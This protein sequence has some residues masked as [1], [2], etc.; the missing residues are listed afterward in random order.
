MKKN[1][2]YNTEAAIA[3]LIEKYDNLESNSYDGVHLDSITLSK[4]QKG[5]FDSISDYEEAEEQ[6]WKDLEEIE[7]FNEM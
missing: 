2:K 7:E 6:F 3:A 1:N 5:L 4:P